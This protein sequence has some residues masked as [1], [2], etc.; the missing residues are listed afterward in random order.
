MIAIRF[1]KLLTISLCTLMLVPYVFLI[2]PILVIYAA[3]KYILT[4]RYDEDIVFVPMDFL[5]DLPYKI[6]KD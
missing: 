5:I 2:F 4:G 6:F 3:A 1:L